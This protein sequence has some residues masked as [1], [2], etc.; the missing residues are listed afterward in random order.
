ML[1]IFQKH[2][3]KFLFKDIK[4]LSVLILFPGSKACPQEFSLYSGEL[5][6]L[7]LDCVLQKLMMMLERRLQGLLESLYITP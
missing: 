3:F 2:F 4:T 1:F 7:F 6:K 5:Y